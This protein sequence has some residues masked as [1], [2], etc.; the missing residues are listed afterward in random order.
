MS[1]TYVPPVGNQIA[2]NFDWSGYVAPAGNLVP[3]VMGASS[4]GDVRYP[5]SS[6]YDLSGTVTFGPTLASIE[7]YCAVRIY[8]SY[9]GL[10]VDSVKVQVPTG[11]FAFSS[12]PSGIYFV[13]AYTPSRVQA[14]KTHSHLQVG[15]L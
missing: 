11:E 2:L 14:A 6:N 1:G 12:L 9:S 4:V 15:V 5:D 7:Q 8:S 13:V 3:I 10:L